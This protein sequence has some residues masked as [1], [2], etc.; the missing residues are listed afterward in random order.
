MAELSRE[1]TA[2]L[3][4]PDGTMTLRP[5][6]AL[7]L[8][9]IAERRGL[10]AP[11]RVGGGKTL[12]TLLAPFV[13]EA[14]RPML[15]LP[16]SLIE[17]TQRELQALAKHWRI[18]RN[19]RMR[20]YQMLGRE[21][22]ANDL[23]FYRPDLLILDEG[24]KGK[25]KKAGVTRRLVRYMRAHPETMVIVLSGTL[26]TN[27]IREFAHLLRW[28]LK[29]GAPIPESDGETDE[30]ADALDEK[31]NPLRR[32]DPGA[33]LTL[34][35][36]EGAEDP[37]T[38]ARRIFRSR[39]MQT[40]GVVNTAGAG[41]SCSLYVSALRYEVGE[42]TERNFH[43]LRSTWTTPDG[44]ALSEA[45]AVWR[46]ARELALGMHYVWDPRPP[47]EWLMSRR[48]WARFVRE[49]LSR[50]RTLDT[51]LQV[52]HACA[53]GALED[54]AFRD[55]AKVRPTY[56]PA[57]KAVWHDDSA[58]RTCQEW[59]DRNQGIVWTEHAFFARELSRR[60]GI[61]YYGAQGLDRQGRYIEDATGPII[62]SVKANCTGRNLQHKWS[63]N[64]ITSCPT[65]QNEW[66]QLIG[67]TH[68]DGQQADEVTVDVLFG[69]WEHFDAFEKARASA[70]MAHDTIGDPNSPPKLLLADIDWPTE[71]ELARLTGA[72]WTKTVE[73]EPLQLSL[74]Q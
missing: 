28:A 36:P 42:V 33:L 3:K 54:E 65:V 2:I 35:P 59:L 53:K 21:Q 69:C 70:Q 14:K 56:T 6:Q 25:N 62:A 20:S 4:T 49:T 9:V 46:H 37:T 68:R 71:I 30:W 8:Y 34:G 17:K 61:P 57:P 51:E 10:F 23:E 11:I 50:S 29:A 26:I 66:E 32:A 13:L 74:G 1:L 73:R 58:L 48:T 5:A 63:R 15:L 19:I 41:V 38:E 67:R 55:W 45:V 52:A 44:W 12:I 27:S 64:L 22:A 72:R 24:H 16:A 47:E 60:T 39:L 40:P 18:P 43:T 7:A 31:I